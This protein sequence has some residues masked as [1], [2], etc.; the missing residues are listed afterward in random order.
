MDSQ[1]AAI[2][3][4]VSVLLLIILG[5]LLRPGK[6]TYSR[7]G[8]ETNRHSGKNGESEATSKYGSAGAKTGKHGSNSRDDSNSGSYSSSRS[9]FSSRSS[10]SASSGS[11]GSKKAYSEK[12]MRALRQQR[13]ERLAQVRAR[14]MKWL[15]EQVDDASLPPKSRYRY[16]LQLIEGF[17]AGNDAFNKK[18]YV[19]ALKQYMAALKDPDASTETRFTCLSQMR[20]TAKMLQ[21]YDLYLELLKQ[22]AQII[23][24]DDLS[25]FGIPKGKG[26]WPLYESRRRF[27]MAI[28]EPNGFEKAIQELTSEPGSPQADEIRKQF[29]KDLQEFKAD[30]ESARAIIESEG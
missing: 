22:Q 5:F 16:R 7:N 28:K 29:E 8:S 19:E 6:G 4:G 12:E 2:I 27:V 26:G 30:F 13:E 17:K 20:M 3:L 11:S 24:T 25:M 15:K 23:E 14:K 1:K 18:D 9:S 21:D 10:S